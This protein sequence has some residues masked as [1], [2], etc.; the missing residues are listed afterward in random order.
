M[1]D[2][3]GGRVWLSVTCLAGT[4][5]MTCVSS[6]NQQQAVPL[7]VY[8]AP[9]LIGGVG[10]LAIALLAFL[11]WRRLAGDVANYKQLWHKRRYSAPPW[12]YHI[13]GRKSSKSSALMHLAPCL[14][15]WCFCPNCVGWLVAVPVCNAA[16]TCPKL[17]LLAAHH[18]H[19]L[20]MHLSF[21]LA[22]VANEWQLSCCHLIVCESLTTSLLQPVLTLSDSLAVKISLHISH[23]Q[24]HCLS[25]C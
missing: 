10:I 20:A 2:H 19:A 13:S 7:A 22:T 3:L 23:S 6:S 15:S 8:L 17:D 9:T 14:T 24:H 4:V 11:Y 21:A 1:V 25:Q 16:G 18:Q 5:S 12:A